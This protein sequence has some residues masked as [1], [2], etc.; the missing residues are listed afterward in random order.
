MVV[1][2]F[3]LVFNLSQVCY[4]DVL[5]TLHLNFQFCLRFLIFFELILDSCMYHF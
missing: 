1:V 2:A 5:Y 4:R 3:S